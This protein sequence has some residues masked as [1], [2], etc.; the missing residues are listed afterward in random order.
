MRPMSK[1]VRTVADVIYPFMAIFGVYLIIHGHLT[2]G[3]GFQGGA[4]VA[5]AFA[6]I[7]VA[8]G[9]TRNFERKT[10]SLTENMG[11]LIFIGL[12]MAGLGTAF[13]FNFLADDGIMFGDE[14]TAGTTDGNI[15]TGG[16]VPLMNIA[17]GM[18][19]AAALCLI[20]VAMA[21]SSGLSD[22]APPS[23]P[24]DPD[25]REGSDNSGDPGSERSERDPGEGAVIPG[26]GD[27][28]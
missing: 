17:V 19:V 14:V 15:N 7:L 13:F 20:L 12:A 6:M 1:I 27:E 28:G 9:T 16:V 2:P 5:S 11:L 21:D 18:E 10:L 23:L 3:G 24:D 22:K 26:G 8:Y 25:E 4:V